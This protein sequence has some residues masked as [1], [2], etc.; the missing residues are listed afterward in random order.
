MRERMKQHV[1]YEIGDGLSISAWYDKWCAIGPLNE[2]IIARMIYD[3]IFQNGSNVASLILNGDWC[4]L[5][6]WVT[7]FQF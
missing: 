6:D 2:F 7:K 5:D 3:D 4:W 1:Y